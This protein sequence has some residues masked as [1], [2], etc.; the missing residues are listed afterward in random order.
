IKMNTN[1]ELRQ[2]FVDQTVP[3]ADYLGLKVPDPD[4]IWNEERKAYGFGDVDWEEFYE[5]LKGNGPCNKERLGARQKA[6]SDGAWF[7]EGLM[8]HAKKREVR[9]MAAE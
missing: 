8:A 5:V 3:Q 1:D 7:R 9:K 2:K 4:L 6:W